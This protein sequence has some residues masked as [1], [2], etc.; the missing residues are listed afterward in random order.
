M[1]SLKWVDCNK[2]RIFTLSHAKRTFTLYFQVHTIGQYLGNFY[3]VLSSIFDEDGS[4]AT[5]G[6]PEE[7]V[8]D[9]ELMFETT[10]LV[11]KT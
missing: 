10:L 5:D 9:D 11:K 6:A 3:D 2:T 1:I 8:D 7:P 4:F